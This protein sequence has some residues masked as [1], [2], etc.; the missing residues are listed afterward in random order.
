[1]KAVVVQDPALPPDQGGLVVRDD[2]PAPTLSANCLLVR[3]AYTALNR[4][5][6]LQRKGLYPPPLGAS[7]ILGLELVGVVEAVGEGVPAGKWSTGD[8]VAALVTGGS[9]AELCVVDESLAMRLPKELPLA[10]AACIPEAWLTA[11]QLLHLVG[12]VKAG[13]Y[14]LIH[15]AASGVG[16]AAI[17]LAQEAGAIVVATASA[18][19]HAPIRALGVAHVIDYTTGPFVEAVKAATPG[20]RGVDLVLDCVAGASYTP[21]NLESLAYG[22]RLVVYG[23]MA[24]SVVPEVDLRVIM[25]KA[26]AIRGTTLRARPLAYKTELVQR[27]WTEARVRKFVNG[28]FK[29]HCFE[30]LEWEEAGKAHALMEKNANGGKIVLTVDPQLV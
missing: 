14:V 15:A 20:G 25:K 30:V 26:L 6:T 19:K 27:F 4:A 9:Y 24:G 17:Q 11:F 28:E 8:R 18:G 3:V 21:Q 5:D 1:M 12:E 13:D 2:V 16:L 23:T 10:T 22:G 29:A 7:E